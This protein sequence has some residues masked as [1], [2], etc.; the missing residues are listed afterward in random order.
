MTSSHRVGRHWVLAL[1]VAAVLGVL[2]SGC[3]DGSASARHGS[4]GCVPAEKQRDAVTAYRAKGFGDYVPDGLQLTGTTELTA[5]CTTNWPSPHG[6]VP[7]PKRFAAVQTNYTAREPL[8]STQILAMFGPRAQASGW[9]RD[10]AWDDPAG[11]G[12][13]YVVYCQ[14]VAGTWAAMSLYRG[15]KHGDTLPLQIFIEGYPD[16]TDCPGKPRD[17]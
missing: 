13:A 10:G 9:Q 1:A 17:G 15:P 12:S 3:A 7:P 2:T 16:A 6:E 4:S 8:T 14:K 11:D 5:D